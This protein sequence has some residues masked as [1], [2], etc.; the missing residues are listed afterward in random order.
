MPCDMASFRQTMGRN[1]KTLKRKTVRLSCRHGILL[2]KQLIGQSL[3]AGR[4][5]IRPRG[6]M[7]RHILGPIG[8]QAGQSLSTATARSVISWT[9]ARRKWAR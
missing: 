6:D 9:A 7:L 5:N 8:D 2:M 3:S 4:A 1:A